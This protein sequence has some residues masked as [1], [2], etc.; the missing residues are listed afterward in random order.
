[1]SLSSALSIAQSSIRN[2]GRQTS[3]VS[4]NVQ[5]SGNPD[6]SRRTAVLS[7]TAP[8]ARV[9]DI[10]RATNEQLFRQNMSAVSAWNAQSTLYAGMESLGLAVN[11]VDNA[12]SAATA[13]GKLQ[14]ALQLYS[15]TPS[16]RNLGENTLDAARGVVR[17]LNDG[18]TAIQTFRVQTDQEIAGAVT[19]LNSLLADFKDANNLVVTGTR[20]GRDVN[21]ALDQRD[22]TLKKIAEY[23]PV[24]TLNRGDNDLVLTTKDGVTLFET[25]PRS[26]TFTPATAYAAGSAGNSVQIDGVPIGA[27]AGGNTNAS[28]KI[29][30]LL[31]L[32]DSVASTMQA[33]LDE[34]ARG[35][36]TAFAE[37]DP[38][39][40][41][42]DA[43]G[44][45]TWQGGPAI[46]PAGQLVDGLAGSIRLNAAIDTEQG[47]AVTLL[48]DGGANGP[49]YVVNTNGDASYSGLLIDLADRMDAPIAFD[50]DVGLAPSAS[51]SNYSS[52]AIGWFESVRQEAS[53]A[54][55]AKQAL[56]VRTAEALSNETGVNVDEEMSLL[57]DLEHSFEA[58]ARLLKAVDEM[59]AALFAAVS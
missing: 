5:E 58:S 32:R 12:T 39:G 34:V 42:P 33:Q 22:A 35:L 27:G 2:T 56:A 21:D 30:G 43:A 31:Q 40:A 54:T 11:G 55:E 53:R 48:R 4:R 10:Q 14:E 1:M 47:G 46:P 16:N 38:S 59:L 18:T 28:G 13:I 7:S 17:S 41:L 6:Y 25:V 26:V 50:T 19:D 57:L 52:S 49:G 3:V 51:L 29:A 24:T 9:V 20:T 23:I 45:F 44:L 36:I 15:S 37:K 8:G